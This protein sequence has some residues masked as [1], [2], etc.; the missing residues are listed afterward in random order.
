MIYIEDDDGIPGVLH[1]GDTTLLGRD[2][3]GVL[4]A[5]IEFE[6]EPLEGTHA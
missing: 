1:V 6:Y 5:E 3:D 4:V 2:D